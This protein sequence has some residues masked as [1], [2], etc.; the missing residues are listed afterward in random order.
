MIGAETLGEALDS[1]GLA[2]RGRCHC[3]CEACSYFHLTF[4]GAAFGRP[5]TRQQ[6]WA[7]VRLLRTG[8][9][10]TTHTLDR[11]IQEAAQ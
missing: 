10:A 5:I 7:L 9:P 8:H 2:I 1:L 4:A 11:A 3:S 6:A